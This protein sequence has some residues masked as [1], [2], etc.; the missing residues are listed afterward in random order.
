MPNHVLN[1]VTICGSKN[2]IAKCKKQI[3]NTY[4]DEEGNFTF[5]FQAIIPRA[6]SLD[7]ESSTCVE[8]AVWYVENDCKE[9]PVS[10]LSWSQEQI[11]KYTELGRIAI[12]N[13]ELYGFYDWYEW[14]IKNWGTKWDCYEV[15][16]DF[17]DETIS[18]EFQTA[19]STP[20]PVF[21]RLSEQYPSLSIR[22]LYADE[23]F[24]SNCGEYLLEDGGLKFDEAYNEKFAYDLWG[25]E[26]PADL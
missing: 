25:Y 19:W 15:S 17:S 7:I 26:M 11:D 9:L 22:V 2:D 3:L 12:K 8:D 16:V 14:S 21:A 10:W 6:K 23:D 1:K 24:G 13:K 18:L 4:K 20:Y 5:S